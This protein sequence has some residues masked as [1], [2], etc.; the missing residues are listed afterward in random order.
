MKFFLS[1]ILISLFTSLSGQVSLW[2][3]FKSEECKFSVMFPGSPEELSEPPDKE[4]GIT[5]NK[6]FALNNG[7]K[8]FVVVCTEFAVEGGQPIV[9]EE[10]IN[11]ARDQMIA[12]MGGKLLEEAPLKLTGANGRDVIIEMPQ[13]LI[14]AGRLLLKGNSFYFVSVRARRAEKSDE[15][16]GKFLNS[17]QFMEASKPAEQK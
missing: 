7:G 6:I 15:S 1:L 2:Q 3:N 10:M 9:A 11:D 12:E 13:D 4:H 8:V 17:F 14:I 16:I 5:K